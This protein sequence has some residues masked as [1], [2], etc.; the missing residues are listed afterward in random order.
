[1]GNHVFVSYARADQAYA[2]TLAAHLRAQDVEMWTDAA[3][4]VGD[5]WGPTI[6]ARIDEGVKKLLGIF[7]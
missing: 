5:E 2:D 1:M 6:Q 3:I 7:A 4:Q